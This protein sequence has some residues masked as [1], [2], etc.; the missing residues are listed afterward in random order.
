MA[1]LEMILN[2]LLGE[3]VNRVLKGMNVTGNGKNNTAVLDE[4][5]DIKSMLDNESKR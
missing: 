1:I 4:M 5:K 2:K 3:A